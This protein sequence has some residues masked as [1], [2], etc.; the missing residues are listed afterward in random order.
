MMI[1]VTINGEKRETSAETVVALLTE[2]KVPLDAKGV[3]VAINGSVIR[4]A[5]WP[6]TT[7]IGGD[8]IEI[9]KPFSGG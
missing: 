5:D 4:K 2:E 3:A 8:V 7:L 9:V 1:S 6:Y